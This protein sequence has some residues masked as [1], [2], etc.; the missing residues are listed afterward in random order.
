MN[1]IKDE[2]M[3]TDRGT[4]FKPSINADEAEFEAIRL[5]VTPIDTGVQDDVIADEHYSDLDEKK[6]H[7]EDEDIALEQATGPVINEIDRRAALGGSSYPFV[8]EGNS[9]KYIPSK[10]KIYE[11]C[12]VTSLQKDI[13]T[14]PYNSLPLTFELIC[15]EV[16]RLYLG[17]N[18]ESFRTGW[19]PYGDRPSNFKELMIQL[20][21]KTGEFVWSPRVTV[22]PS[23][24]LSDT[25]DEG[26]D[27]VAWKRFPDNRVGGVY[28]LGQCACGQNWE[29]KI[30]ELEHARLKRW[31]DP[32]T[33]AKYI[34]SFAVPH[35]IPG[36]TIF[37]E[38]CD[39]A[40]LVFDRLR[41]SMIAEENS[42]LI[43]SELTNK[44]IENIQLFIKNYPTS[45]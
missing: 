14:A 28:L 3:W 30:T 37:S 26:L 25:K 18:A 12:L 19:P 35:H 41:L 42:D 31:L 20:S 45:S 38:L 23:N 4:L 16:V 9:L 22:D 21:K 13:S 29:S 10:T 33:W 7:W 44:A 1:Y 6:Q 11:N 36:H 32:V 2:T 24:K 34:K 40:G 39:R 5:G 27:F 15:T 17:E 8:R 43:S